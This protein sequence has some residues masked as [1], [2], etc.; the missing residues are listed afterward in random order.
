MR[1]AEAWPL[2]SSVLRERSLDAAVAA[3]EPPP[4]G[5]TKASTAPECRGGSEG[6]HAAQISIAVLRLRHQT[7]RGLD[8]GSATL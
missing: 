2:A 1:L 8:T 3:I 5:V 7:S 4:A 6:V